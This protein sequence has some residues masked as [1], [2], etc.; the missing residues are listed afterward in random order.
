MKDQ[1]NSDFDILDNYIE[2]L[3]KEDITVPDILEDG[4]KEHITVVNRR[5]NIF[6]TKVY[7]RNTAVACL[8][9]FIFIGLSVW[10]PSVST[11]AK[12]I[13]VIGTLIEFIKG[14]DVGTQNAKNNGYNPVQLVTVCEDGYTFAVNSM[15]MDE[16]RMVMQGTVTGDIFKI[17]STESP[18]DIDMN[19][20]YMKPSLNFSGS[21]EGPTYSFKL[22]YNFAAGELNEIL[23]RNREYLT[24]STLIFKT[25]TN[26]TN[27][28]A[29][30]NSFF[31][32]KNVPKY[33]RFDPNNDEVV[34][35][36][37]DIKIPILSISNSHVIPINKT[38]NLNT[39]GIQSFDIS[40]NNLIINPT[41][42]HLNY[43]IPDKSILG[44][45]FINPCIK[46]D[47]GN[48]YIEIKG[49]KLSPNE[50][51]VFF[52]PSTYF[53]SSIKNLYFSFDG[54]GI[55]NG[56]KTN[57]LDCRMEILLYTNQ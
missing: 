53:D 13:P 50:S 56:T 10:I 31:D 4:I 45:Y 22:E 3:K 49:T 34:K 1:L 48:V 27:R 19:I 52:A 39:S 12:N 11:Y 41:R 2:S 18:V 23:K 9:L 21:S 25:V 24:L 38:I 5:K 35:E 51:S 30:G 26:Q 47:K 57:S 16:D 32:V 7:L 29:A 37:K 55:N 54:I 36:L 6:K 42:M 28:K 33:T 40:L 44:F 8:M 15:T 14:T 17:N 46:D 20:E 43:N